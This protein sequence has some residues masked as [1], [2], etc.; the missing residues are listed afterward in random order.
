VDH[1]SVVHQAS[2]NSHLEVVKHLVS[3]GADI[4]ADNDF[5]T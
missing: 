4:K 2:G 5:A 3:Q 1:D